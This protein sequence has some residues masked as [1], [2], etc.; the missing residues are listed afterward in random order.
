MRVDLK[1]LSYCVGVHSQGKSLGLRVRDPLQ[2][3]CEWHSLV[4][5]PLVQKT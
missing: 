5:A 1:V 2:V 4:S 3:G